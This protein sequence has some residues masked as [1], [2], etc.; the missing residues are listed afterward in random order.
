MD[1]PSTST[2]DL[3]TPLAPKKVRSKRP[4]RDLTNMEPTVLSFYDDEEETMEPPQKD[5]KLTIDEEDKEE[6]K[7]MLSGND[8]VYCHEHLG[9]RCFAVAKSFKG[10]DYVDIRFFDKRE[11]DTYVPTK[12]GITL[13]MDQWKRLVTY[14][15]DSVLEKTE[16]YG[17]ATDVQ[18]HL[19]SNTYVTLKGDYKCVNI[20]KWFMPEDEEELRPTRKGIALN[21]TIFSM[22]QEVVPTIN[23]ALGDAYISTELCEHSDSHNNQM[24]MLRCKTCNPNEYQDW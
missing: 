18:I 9:Q 19:G 2:V 14:H 6:F 4:M 1:S 23:A 22:L 10:K 3:Q 16:E 7:L 24:G 5:A 12:K 17:D 11:N 13:T 8:K 20:R 15:I 21:F